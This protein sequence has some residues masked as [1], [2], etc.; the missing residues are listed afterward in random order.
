MPL[1]AFWTYSFYVTVI[2]GTL[3]IAVLLYGW[4]LPEKGF[5][6]ILKN[7]VEKWLAVPTVTHRITLPNQTCEHVWK[8]LNDVENE[9]SVCLKQNLHGCDFLTSSQVDEVTG[10]RDVKRQSNGDVESWKDDLGSGNTTLSWKQYD[11]KRFSSL[12]REAVSK[13]RKENKN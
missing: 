6:Q 5:L 2:V 3:V 10:T 12:K 9:K 13:H 7:W 8:V 1:S 11:V 4:M